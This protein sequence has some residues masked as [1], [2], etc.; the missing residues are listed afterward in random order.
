MDGKIPITDYW[1]EGR[2]MVATLEKK[3][4]AKFPATRQE[5]RDTTIS[6]SVGYD[7]TAF[8]EKYAPLTNVN[9][10]QRYT[11]TGRESNPV[12][13]LMY[14][15]TRPYSPLLGL[16]LNR[17]PWGYIHRNFSLYDAMSQNP[18][19]RTEPFS[20]DPSYID[21]F[22]GKI[23]AS[24]L[25]DLL[26][27]SMGYYGYAGDFLANALNEGNNLSFGFDSPI[28][29][30]ILQSSEFA[31]MINTLSLNMASAMQSDIPG[32]QDAMMNFWGKMEL[33]FNTGKLFYALH[34]TDFSYSCEL[35]I[36]TVYDEKG[37]CEYRVVEGPCKIKIT[38]FYNFEASRGLFGTGY[39]TKT[40]YRYGF[41][42]GST[43]NHLAFIA[44][45]G[46]QLSNFFIT[47]EFPWRIWE[48]MPC[49]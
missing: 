49:P 32:T 40:N 2:L 41:S 22:N 46:G 13:S 10:E 25:S 31:D 28:V 43:L 38:D 11:Y 29:D 47:I 4:P 45:K 35:T 21:I 8:G 44:Q 16:M 15:R 9:V 17:N 24:L 20:N 18:V 12:S 39:G 42:F 26:T 23:A 36:S 34:R 6:G 3:S 7:Y 33:D 37:C 30:D 19:L 14:Y 48:K 5:T 27:A 1:R